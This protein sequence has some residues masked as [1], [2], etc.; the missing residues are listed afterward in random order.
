[1]AI[2]AL[3]DELGD[4]LGRVNATVCKIVAG[5]KVLERK[6]LGRVEP[7]PSHSKKLIIGKFSLAG[8]Q[9]THT[10]SGNQVLAILVL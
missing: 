5:T 10:P 6:L 4:A 8:A 1:M 9:F 2:T 7:L 3:R